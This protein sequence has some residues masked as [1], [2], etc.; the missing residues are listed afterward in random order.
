MIQMTM[1]DKLRNVESYLFN[2]G[3]GTLVVS[4]I[5]VF[6]KIDH[7]NMWKKLGPIEWAYPGELVASALVGAEQ[8]GMSWKAM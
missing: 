4:E 3:P 7:G 1:K 6:Y 5:E 8:K 2:Q